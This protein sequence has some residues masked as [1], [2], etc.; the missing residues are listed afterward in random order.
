MGSDVNTAGDVNNDGV[1][2]FVIGAALASTNTTN[3][4][5][6]YVLFGRAPD[7]D[8]DG[9]F[10]ASDNCLNV[11]NENQRDTDTDGYGNLCDPDLNNDGIVNFTDISLWVPQFNSSGDDADFNGD[12][13]VNFIDYSI[14][15]SFFLL[16]PG[17]S[18]LHVTN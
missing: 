10:N 12:G 4:G 11:A 14:L 3:A 2:D 18:G 1:A 5:E 17:P 7:S 16:P 13:S 9:V 8:G 15:V 6:S